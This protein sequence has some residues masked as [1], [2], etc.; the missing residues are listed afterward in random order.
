MQLDSCKYNKML[1][2]KQYK[3]KSRVWGIQRLLRPKVDSN[4]RRE[5]DVINIDR[6]LQQTLNAETLGWMLLL[7]SKFISSPYLSYSYI[8]SI[9]L[10]P[11]LK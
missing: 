10:A 9:F 2:I 8:F 4:G 5:A 3:V 11:I 7:C 6:G 1:H